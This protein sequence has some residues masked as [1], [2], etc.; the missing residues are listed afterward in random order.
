VDIGPELFY[1]RRF[2]LAEDGQE[3]YDDEGP[4]DRVLGEIALA[5]IGVDAEAPIVIDGKV[6]RTPILHARL[7]TALEARPYKP[8]THRQM[9]TLGFLRWLYLQPSFKP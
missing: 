7:V 5:D 3:A 6:V 4:W 8:F 2:Y 9:N 1:V